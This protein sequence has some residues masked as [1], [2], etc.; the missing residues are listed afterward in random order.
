MDEKVEIHVG[1]TG[2]EDKKSFVAVP[3]D[4]SE[5]ESFIKWQL[6]GPS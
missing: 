3:I 2:K 5:F 4:V 1:L 6:N